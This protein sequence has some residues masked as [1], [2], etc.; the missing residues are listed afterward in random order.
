MGDQ[1]DLLYAVVLIVR[2]GQ[3]ENIKQKGLIETITQH[4]VRI[5]NNCVPYGIVHPDYVAE[6]QSHQY[7]FVIL[8]TLTEHIRKP[9][10]YCGK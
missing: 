7:F 5:C 3:T 8:T 6:T 2:T 10:L 1:Q 9:L 4:V